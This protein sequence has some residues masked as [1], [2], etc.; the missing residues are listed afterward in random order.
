MFFSRAVLEAMRLLDLEVDVIHANDWQTGLI[1]AYLKIEYHNTAALRADRQLVHHPQHIVPGSVLALGHAVDRAGLEVFQLAPD[2]ISRE[3]EHVEDRHGVRG[4]D[5]HGQP[6][7]CPGNSEQSA[8]LRFGRRAAISARRA[9]GHPQR[10]RSAEWNPA[11][12]K[13][14]PTNYDSKCVRQGKAQCKAA[15]QKELGLPQEPGS[16]A[17]R[18]DRPAYGS[19]RHG[20]GGRGNAALGADRRRAMGHFGHGPAQVSQ[21]F[22]KRLSQRFPQKAAVRLEFS[23]PLAHRIEAGADMFLMPSQFEPCG[24]NQLYSLNYGT[25]PVVR[26]T[27]GLADTIVGLRRA[28]RRVGPGQWLQ[29]PGIQFLALSETLRRACDV[30]RQPVVWSRLIA[31]GMKQDWSWTRSAKQ[32]AE[33]YKTTVA[34]FRQGSAADDGASMRR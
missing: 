2:G 34:R 17:G 8:G 20:P 13:F 32:Y 15:L 10:H 30:Y 5:Q 14:L 9:V 11:T 12:D 24:L 29:L 4:L 28:N 18:T 23:N 21:A 3:I 22:W 19:K 26:A 25:V 31:T 33:L 6:A 16:A 7:L 27:G 1:P